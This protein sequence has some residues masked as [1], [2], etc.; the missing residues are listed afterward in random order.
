MNYQEYCETI[1]NIPVPEDLQ[2]DL[3]ICWL[4]PSTLPLTLVSI[5]NSGAAV[6]KVPEK[7]KDRFDRTVP[8]FEI[9]PKAF[10]GH[11]DVT[12]II[13]PASITY[14]PAGAFAGCTNL[15]NITIPRAV[16]TIPE[17][18]FAACY[19]L[20]NVFYEGSTEEWDAIRIVHD[21]H[22]VEFG[23]CIPGTP[24]NTVVSERREHIPGNEPLF[25]A[26]I[27]FQ[28][29]LTGSAAPRFRITLD[30]K[31]VTALFRTEP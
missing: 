21:R 1:K 29:P 25:A 12:D 8:V 27:H 2:F 31:D 10:A 5:G 23:D 22:V 4:H 9:S 30:G 15:K 28:C 11:T 20:E 7:A 3:E 18:T 19:H 26:N 24:V 17:K 6:I 13:L 14:L 16:K